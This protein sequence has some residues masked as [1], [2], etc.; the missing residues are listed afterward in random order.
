VASRP[1]SKPT[2]PPRAA[3]KPTP[4]ATSA[5]A[6]TSFQQAD[7]QRRVKDVASARQIYNKFVIDNTQR[8]Q[9]FASVRNQMEGGRPFDQNLLKAQGAAWQTN[10]NFGDAQ[11]ARDRTLL[12]YWKM[13][14]DVPH[15]AAFTIRANSPQSDKWQVALAEAYDDFVTDWGS[16]YQIQFMNFCAN[17]V[18]FGP[19]IMQWFDKSDPRCGAVNV[20]RIYFPKNGRMSPKAWDV[21]ALVADMSPSELYIKVRDRKSKKRSEYLGWNIKAVEQAVA[22]FK[23]GTT[24]PNPYDATRW[25]DMYVNNDI[26]VTS[27]FQPL[28]LVWLFVRK[29]DGT[30]SAQVFTQQGG[31][32]DFLFEDANYAKEFKEILGPVWY[33]T[34]TDSMIHSIKGFGIK[35]FYFSTL[36]NRVKSRIVDS[37]TMAMGMNFQRDQENVPDESPPVENYGPLNVFPTG[38]RQ[39]QYYPQLAQGAQLVE[40]LQGNRDQNNSLYRD[41]Q[42]TDIANT[43]TAKQ[44]EI[45]ASM[46]A[47]TTQSSASIFLA[48]YG[49]NVISEQVRRLRLK[50]SSNEDAKN[51]V[52]RLKAAGVPD[53]II[54]EVDDSPQ[55]IVTT[56]ANAAMANP[57]IRV[58]AFKEGLG[59][60]QIPGVNGRYFLEGLIANRYG[61]AAVSKALLPEGAQSNPGQRRQAKME[62]MDFAQGQP[63]E[64]A[65]EDDH[66]V[67]AQEH[68]NPLAQL[69]QQYQ[70]TQQVSPEQATAL[71]IGL[72]HTGE[73]MQ[74][75]SKDETMKQQFQQVVPVF[76]NVQSVVRGMLMQ[77]AKQKQLQSQGAPAQNA[78]PITQPTAA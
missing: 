4:S 19:G 78:G 33:D 72:E 62:N 29:F 60:S 64:V 38:I 51:W 68:L 37:G 48:Q 5:G 55:V 74:Y 34:G 40:M 2:P 43:D 22:Q 6:A 39:L 58:Q 7:D 46:Q 71:T 50:G 27:Q 18:N 28:Q 54:Y 76:R 45:L 65:P 1:P 12:P 41:Q 11:A 35:N 67:H 53:N 52:K 31:V 42:Q 9:T 66:F 26:Y 10:V 69:A 14:N 59:L 57:A 3:Q 23:D 25:Q 77:L 56:G 61:S 47:D 73:H 24:W 44:A 13:V 70:A 63:L 21:V 75:L 32:E 8:S 16:D 36:I 30:I 15:K 17:F 49:E 20:Q